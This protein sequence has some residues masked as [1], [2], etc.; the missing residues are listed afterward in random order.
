M[1]LNKLQMKSIQ[2][3]T[4]PINFQDKA[5]KELSKLIEAISTLRSLF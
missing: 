2:A 5:Y 4:Y 3:A 1:Q